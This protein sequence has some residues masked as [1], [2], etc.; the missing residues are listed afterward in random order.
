M[1]RISQHLYFSFSFTGSFKFHCRQ[2]VA[3][4]ARCERLDVI[5][6]QVQ[7]SA[8]NLANGS[9]FVCIGL[10]SPIAEICE[11]DPTTKCNGSECLFPELVQSPSVRFSTLCLN[12]PFSKQLAGRLI[13]CLID[14]IFARLIITK[15]RS[16]YSHNQRLIFKVTVK[17]RANIRNIIKDYSRVA[18]RPDE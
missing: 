11:L 14:F 6:G 17:G 8:A 12:S 16:V 18:K 1:V 9:G 10:E 3:F 5:A 13:R 4:D 15:L 2:G 7:G